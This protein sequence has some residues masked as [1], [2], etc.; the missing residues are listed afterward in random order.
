MCG[1]Q[2]NCVREIDEGDENVMLLTMASGA[3]VRKWYMY[4]ST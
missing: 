1:E 4:D 2:S 3:W